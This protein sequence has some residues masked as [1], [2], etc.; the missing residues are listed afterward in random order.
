MQKFNIGEIVRTKGTGIK[1]PGYI[2]QIQTGIN[3]YSSVTGRRSYEH[4]AK[5]YGNDIINYPVYYLEL[6]AEA[7]QITFL[8]YCTAYQIP[9]CDISKKIYQ[10]LV[11]LT[12][13]VAACEADLELIAYSKDEWFNTFESREDLD[14][15][16]NTYK[17]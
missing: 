16:L 7:R 1:K 9:T 4:W 10:T 14:N 5:L 17:D 11:P 12:K 13:T 2:Y 8:E 3:Y 6:P 15:F